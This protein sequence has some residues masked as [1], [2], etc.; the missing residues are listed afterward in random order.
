MRRLLLEAVLLATGGSC[1]DGG[2]GV[3]V[4]LRLPSD[5]E[6][7]WTESPEV[8]VGRGGRRMES[9]LER[10]FAVVDVMGNEFERP[11][12]SGRG[13]WRVA[14]V[15]SVGRCVVLVLVG[16]TLL[17]PPLVGPPMVCLP[18]LDAP[19]LCFCTRVDSGWWRSFLFNV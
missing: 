4:A 17:E 5:G 19:L 16:L 2:G 6:S 12:A 9:L 10:G 8:E 14:L 3:A 18:L 13:G 15:G 7:P 1:G 11:I